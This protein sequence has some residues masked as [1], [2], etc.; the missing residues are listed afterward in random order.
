MQLILV[1]PKLLFL[2]ISNLLRCSHLLLDLLQL[3]LG[4][5]LCRMQMIRLH[6]CIVL[7]F[8]QLQAETLGVA[9][10]PSDK[11]TKS[12]VH[13]RHAR[14]IIEFLFQR[15]KVSHGLFVV[16]IS[17][18]LDNIRQYLI[19]KTRDLSLA[20]QALSVRLMVP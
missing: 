2:R 1:P 5:L 11:L 12:R 3:R 15:R 16:G 10:L 6:I 14:I 8:L 9:P 17:I 13:K 7:H 4:G 18:K 20:L 19:D